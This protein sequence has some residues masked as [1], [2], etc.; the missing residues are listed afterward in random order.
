MNRPR[1]CVISDLDGT[2]LNREG[3]MDDDII[4][5]LQQWISNRSIHFTAATARDI[6]DCRQALGDLKIKIPM[7]LCNGAVLY[8]PLSSKVIESICFSEDER[9]K[10]LSA[11]DL[12]GYN[13]SMV[14]VAN[15]KL[16]RKA[17]NSF[18]ADCFVVSASL[19]MDKDKWLHIK[20]S[21]EKN[22]EG[23]I[24][25]EYS[26]NVSL[27]WVI[28]D[29]NPP[30]ASKGRW[31]SYLKKTLGKDDRMPT[32]CFGDGMNDVS[33]L[34]EADYGIAVGES[35]SDELLRHA[36]ERIA[37]SEGKSVVNTI[38]LMLGVQDGLCF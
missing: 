21:V 12:C 38:E 26:S 33:L 24:L 5:I 36:K 8:N 4:R 19:H 1:F 17:A 10:I 30:G 3:K 7:I 16:I 31:V 27:G 11:L 20:P 28:I 2:L 35:C 18:G 34:S 23:M 9:V 22:C 13:G 32:V 37:Y 15:D 29:I 6:I 25:S 14:C